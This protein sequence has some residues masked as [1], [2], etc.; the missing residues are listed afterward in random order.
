MQIKVESLADLSHF[1]VPCAIGLEASDLVDRDGLAILGKA[2]LCLPVHWTSNWFLTWKSLS[3]PS[4]HHTTNECAE[5]YKRVIR[6]SIGISTMSGKPSVSSSSNFQRYQSSDGS[7]TDILPVEWLLGLA[8]GLS[9][10]KEASLSN[11]G[12]WCQPIQDLT[13]LSISR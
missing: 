1:E 4:A 8:K 13:P 7:F 5:P 12:T 2:L 3:Y 10:C 6:Q 9:S 11:F